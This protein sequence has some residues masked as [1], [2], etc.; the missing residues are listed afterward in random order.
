MIMKNL[1]MK[2]WFHIRGHGSMPTTKIT[3][4]YLGPD[5]ISDNY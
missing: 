4:A 1:N 2:P 5:G 3:L